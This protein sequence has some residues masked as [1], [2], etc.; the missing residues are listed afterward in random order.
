MLNDANRFFER[1]EK[2]EITAVH[3]EHGRNVQRQKSFY[4]VLSREKKKQLGC[5]I[6]RLL[7]QVVQKSRDKI[8]SLLPRSRNFLAPRFFFSAANRNR[9]L[10]TRQVR[11]ST[12]H[13]LFNNF[14][15]RDNV[16]IEPITDRADARAK[17]FH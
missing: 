14:F 1:K 16:F 10:Y 12:M 13:R 2:F 9:T 4:S 7:E 5:L 8:V 3:L 17:Y 15:P 6:Y 11:S